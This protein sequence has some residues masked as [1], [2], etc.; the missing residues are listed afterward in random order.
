MSAVADKTL[1]R[2]PILGEHTAEVLGEIGISVD[3][4]KTLQSDGIV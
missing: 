1:A 4:L 2:P 3:E